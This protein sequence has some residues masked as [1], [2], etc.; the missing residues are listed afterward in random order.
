MISLLISAFAAAAAAAA[1]DVGFRAV[2]TNLSKDT[3]KQEKVPEVYTKL[4]QATL[5]I[6][7]SHTGDIDG[8]YGDETKRSVRAF[9]AQHG[10]EIDGIAGVDTLEM[11]A[12]QLVKKL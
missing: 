11:I 2:W 12:L 9:Q 3:A 6:L 10:L 4:V 1:G 8:H 5:A 7:G